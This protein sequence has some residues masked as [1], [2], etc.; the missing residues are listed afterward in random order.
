[1]EAQT[2]SRDSILA[3]IRENLPK[4]RVSR[5]GIPAFAR[6]DQPIRQMFE[7]HLGKAG[8]AAHSIGS[9]AEAAAK[10]TAMF[11]EAK[12]VCSAVPEIAGTRRAADVQDPHALADV[13]VGVFRAQFGVVEGGAVWVT[14]EDLIVTALG[15]LSQH[16]VVLLDPNE[17]VSDMHQAYRRVRMHETA[18]GCFMAGP[19]ATAD[20]EATLVHGAQGARSLDVFFLRRV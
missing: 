10:L 15:F 14:Q 5:P 7:E 12:V 1:M 4:E 3:A 16:L 6:Q 17:I 9:P 2:L 20:I 18:Y 19:S 8:A 11:P 13:D